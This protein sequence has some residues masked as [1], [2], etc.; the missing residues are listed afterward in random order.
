MSIFKE[1]KKA[2]QRLE[3]GVSNM[4]P[5]T[6]SAERRSAMQQARSQIDFYRDLK[7]DFAKEREEIKTE[8]AQENARLEKK[9]VRALRRARRQ[10]GFLEASQQGLS[11]KLG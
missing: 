2:G 4:I 10:P 8:K 1:L 9:Q 6:H 5:H 3:R 7:N 11:D